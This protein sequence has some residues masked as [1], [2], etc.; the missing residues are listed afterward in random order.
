LEAVIKV[1]KTLD[2]IPTK[3]VSW[4][5]KAKKQTTSQAQ[6]QVGTPREASL[7]QGLGK[8]LLGMSVPVGGQG[9]KEVI[10]DL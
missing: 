10:F 3:R 9:T 7:G 2:P 8:M 6:S 4:T 5:D 1:Q